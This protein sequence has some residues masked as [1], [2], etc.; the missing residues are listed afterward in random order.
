MNL[1][2]SV[3]ITGIDKPEVLDQAIA[4]AASFAPLTQAQVEA[5]LAQTAALAGDGACERY[6]TSR[7]FDDTFQNPSWLG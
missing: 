7:F 3:V 4:A 1:P 6:K 5:I 2:T